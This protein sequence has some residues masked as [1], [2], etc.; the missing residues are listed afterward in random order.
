[1]STLGLLGFGEAGYYIG[2]G[3]VQE[4]CAGLAA[5]DAALG[6]DGPYRQTVLD[7]ARDAGVATRSS[8]AE[9]VASSDIILCLVPSQ[10]NEAAAMSV[11]PHAGSKTL[12]VDA[13][14]S[15]PLLKERLAKAFKDKGV[16]YVDAAIMSAVPAD[17]HRV[18][19]NCSGDG[20]VAFADAMRPY[21]MRITILDGDPGL[22]SRIKLARS[23][24][25]KGFEALCIEAFLFAKTVGL[26]KEI[27]ESVSASFG[28]EPVETMMTRMMC[29]GA[30]HA[31]RRAHEAEEARD[32]MEAVGIVPT[33][34]NGAIDRLK[35]M[36]AL[37]LKEELGGLPPKDMPALYGLWEKKKFV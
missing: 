19:M 29:T 21:G 1:M 13:T 27:M 6:T 23:V 33:V 9:L 20:A 30:I 8:V 10:H 26:E 2:K 28:K 31:G 4:G 32:L 5:Y 3:L 35:R 18:P 7:R 15:S 36:E 12:Y 14:S 24:F 25:M 34:T 11:L 17:G 37:G 22:A 16:R